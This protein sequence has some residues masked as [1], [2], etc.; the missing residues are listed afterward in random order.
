MG[1]AI[2][3]IVPKVVEG[4]TVEIEDVVGI[5]IVAIA[6]KVVKG[7]T[8]ESEVVVVGIAV[9]ALVTNVVEVV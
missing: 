3:V 9:A 8:V 6:D 1:I 7:E 5:A 2:A 4:A